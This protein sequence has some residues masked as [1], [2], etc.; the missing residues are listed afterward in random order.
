MS[1]Y[2]TVSAEAVQVIATRAPIDLQI[3]ELRRWS[4]ERRVAGLKVG[5]VFNADIFLGEMMSNREK[6]RT[7]YEYS[8]EIIKRKEVKHRMRQQGERNNT[9]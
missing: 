8:V 2:R 4:N 5:R 3:A 6:W 7:G 1:G 9:E